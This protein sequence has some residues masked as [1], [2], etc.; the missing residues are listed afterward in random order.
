MATG[1]AVRGERRAEGNFG[2]G[3]RGVSAPRPD[4]RAAAAGPSALPELRDPSAL[5]AP[6]SACSARPRSPAR[7]PPSLAP[8]SR[9]SLR[10]PAPTPARPGPATAAVPGIPSER[11]SAAS[12]MDRCAPGNREWGSGS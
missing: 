3:G 9:P 2:D 10:T 4:G 7:P 5:P 8:R 12:G 1:S 11:G 6:Q